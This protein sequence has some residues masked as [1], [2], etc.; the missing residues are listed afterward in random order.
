MALVIIKPNVAFS[1]GDTFV[2]GSWVY[3]ANG[4]GSFQRY[5]TLTPDP[6]SGF[7]TLPEASTDQLAENFG[8]ISLSDPIRE[9]KPKFESN[10][11][12]PRTWSEPRELAP[13]PALGSEFY[14]PTLPFGLRNAGAVYAAAL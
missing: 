1:R 3:I 8:E 12:P 13:E 7:V 5:L 9:L 14:A 4:A 11:T 10:P 6:K 2:F